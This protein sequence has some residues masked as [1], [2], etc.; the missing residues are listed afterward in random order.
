[1][2]LFGIIA[3]LNVKMKE[4]YGRISEQVDLRFEIE[5]VELQPFVMD[6]PLAEV[7]L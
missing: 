1:L 7:L 2:A 5:D 3:T 6:T 4:E